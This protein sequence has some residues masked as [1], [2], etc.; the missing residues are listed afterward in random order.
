M[1]SRLVSRVEVL[2]EVPST[3]DRAR[4]LVASG[5]GPGTLVL[6]LRQTSGRGRMG[7]RWESPPGGLYMTLVLE[8]DDGR[9]RLAL[10][11]VAALAVRT[12]LAGVG[13]ETRLKWPN[14]VFAGR[15]K[16]AGVIAEHR[17]GALLLGVGVDLRVPAQAFPPELRSAATSVLIETGTAPEPGVFADAV[18][19]A[20][21]PLH[22][23]WRAADA[24]LLALAEQAMI[25][26]R[27][28]RWHAPSGK[29]HQGTPRRLGPR[30][31]LAIETAPGEEVV[32]HAGDLEI[33]WTTP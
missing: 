29:I 19:C 32:A 33:V 22:A 25:L 17:G 3:M 6:A 10:P 4:E 7:H 18:L 13:V 26:D 11:I 14:D 16:I 27:P 24:G 31:E 28:V 30:G 20:L 1:R 12:A 8:R 15:R 21:E 5:A 9:E 2:A 23:R